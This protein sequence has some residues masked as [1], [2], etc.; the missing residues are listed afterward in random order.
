MYPVYLGDLFGVMNLPVLFGIMGI[1]TSVSAGIG[2]AL[3]GF[4]HDLAGSYSPAFVIN[5][6]FCLLSALLLLFI[7]PAKGN[8]N[9]GK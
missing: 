9:H 3:Y 5:G 8:T 1:F 4:S 2:P 6:L 7:T